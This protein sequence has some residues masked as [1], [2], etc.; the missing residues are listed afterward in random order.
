MR[1]FLNRFD[2]TLD[3]V[4]GFF[5]GVV[6]AV[7][8]SLAALYA[9]V[10]F[11]FHLVWFAGAAVFS[12]LLFSVLGLF[13]H[14]Y[15]AC[16]FIPVFAA[17]ANPDGHPHCDDGHSRKGWIASI[18]LFLALIALF[19]GALFQIHMS[20]AAGAVLFVGY[21]LF[22]PRVFPERSSV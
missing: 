11:R 4:L 15:F 20:F 8:A 22:A 17:F 3:R 9:C 19:V 13:I 7:A 2:N 12:L 21:S 10:V 14:R 5:G 16:F 1:Q 6:C 18:S